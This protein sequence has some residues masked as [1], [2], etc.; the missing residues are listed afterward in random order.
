MS[1]WNVI[2][3]PLAWSLVGALGFAALG[4]TPARQ[5]DGDGVADAWALPAPQLADPS[6]S[7]AA[8]QRP[9]AW[10]SSPAAAASAATAVPARPLPVLLGVVVVSG[11][12]LALFRLADGQRVRV[13]RGD[14]FDDGAQVE[15]IEPTRVR[16]RTASG[17]ARDTRLL[18]TR[19]SP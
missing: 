9:G 7:D 6:E 15:V 16:W 1:R 14:L 10:L 17:E 19:S 13:G 2:R 18:D 11:R 5:A 3:G 12:P 8:W 4:D